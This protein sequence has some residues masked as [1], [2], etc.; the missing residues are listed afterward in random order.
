MQPQNE[1]G[2]KLNKHNQ[3][4]AALLMHTYTGLLDNNESDFQEAIE[5]DDQQH[6]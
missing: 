6:H 1:G 2:K 4:Y 5:E 3:M